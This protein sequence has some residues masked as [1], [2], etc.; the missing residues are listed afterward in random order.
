[1][2]TAILISK[3][4]HSGFASWSSDD[5]FVY[6]FFISETEPQVKGNII[7]GKD[8]IIK[9]DDD[10]EKETEIELKQDPIGK[11]NVLR[12]YGPPDKTFYNL[13]LRAR[14]FLDHYNET[15][16]FQALVQ[17]YKDKDWVLREQ[18]PQTLTDALQRIAD[19][20]EKA[21]REERQQR[22]HVIVVWSRDLPISAY[23][24]AFSDEVF[25]DAGLQQY[26]KNGGCHGYIGSSERTLDTDRE[27][28]L[29]MR[30][31]G[32]QID[33]IGYFLRHSAGRHFANQLG[34]VEEVRKYLMEYIPDDKFM[35]LKLSLPQS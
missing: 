22:G 12:V 7:T 16:E 14:V 15:P 17:S 8:L 33:Q 9:L 2:P 5:I 4:I 28:E 29:L 11:L 19:A 31:K 21:Y 1:M 3:Q 34:G 6:Q 27:V 13:A 32:Y 30:A 18:F 35:E 20:E 25:Q 26:L 10:P 23:Q 24:G